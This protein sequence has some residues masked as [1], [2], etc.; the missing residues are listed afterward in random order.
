MK[1]NDLP[2][3]DPVIIEN[4]E[5]PLPK[6]PNRLFQIIS[7][8]GDKLGDVG[9]AVK[10]KMADILIGREVEEPKTIIT[11]EGI[12]SGINNGGR[13]GGVVGFLGD[14]SKG[15][16]ENMANS[17]SP[18]NLAPAKKGFGY[19]LG[20]A[21]GTG[22]RLLDNSLVRGA[23][24]Y[25][26]S[27]Y[28]GDYNPLEQGLIALG[29]NMQNKT[30]DRL[31]RQD[32]ANQGIDAS[33]IRGFINDNTYS[34]LIRSKQLRDNE[35]YRNQ[36]LA[37]NMAQQEA[38][39]QYRKNQLAVDWAT[40]NQ[41]GQKPKTIPSGSVENLS[42]TYQGLIQMRD[43]MDKLPELPR[44]LTMPGVA[45]ASAINPFDTDA[46]AFNQYVKTYKQVIGKGLEGGVLRKEDE[47]KYDQIIPKVGDTAEV[48]K[49]KAEQLNQM[50]LNKYN[51]DL[52]FLEMSGY[53]T[54]DLKTIETPRTTQKTN[55][56]SKY[57]EGQT[58][59]NPQTGQKMIF[60]G[61]QWQTL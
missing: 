45:Q 4:M 25:G 34:N 55:T 43:L 33:N 29:T 3:I 61:G 52:E 24:A 42:A 56:Q 7:G 13:Q 21:L 18:M 23:L 17:F 41:K 38:L 10:N 50:L 59:T 1:N 35:N 28:N 54:A 32:L 9:G 14:M 60:R 19:R 44:R 53:N 31:Y 48:L 6:Q 39:N 37:S 12:Q 27:K 40:L 2:K 57:V 47:Y 5:Y 26:L 30:N 15:A 11:D 8:V 49:Q 51:S 36:I 58:A 46:Q 22:A 20:E 16:K